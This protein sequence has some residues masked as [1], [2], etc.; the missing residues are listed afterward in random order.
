MVAPSRSGRKLAPA[1]LDW[2][3]EHVAEYG[4]TDL[5]PRPFEI[6]L[7]SKHRKVTIEALKD[8][9]ITSHLW[10]PSRRFLVPKGGLSFRPIVQL[11]PIDSIILSA[12]VHEIGGGIERRRVPAHEKVVFSNRFTPLGD[13]TLYSPDNSWEA[14]WLAS[15]EKAR[16]AAF[17]A[18]TDI[19]DFYNQIAHHT[20]E[21][22]LD[23]SG[24]DP[25]IKRPILRL[26]Q[27]DTD[28][29]SRG[30][31]I[32][33]H[34][35]HLIAEMALIPTDNFLRSSRIDYC[36]F[37]D[38][39]HIF[40]KGEVQAQARLQQ[41]AEYLDRTQK[42]GLSR[43]K[44]MVLPAAEFQKIC[45]DHLM[46]RPVNELE[47]RMLDIVKRYSSSPYVPVQIMLLDRDEQAAFSKEN[48]ETVLAA[49]L[50]QTNIDHVRLRWT[51]RRLAQVGAPGGVEFCLKNFHKMAPAVAEIAAYLKSAEK[52]YAGSWAD[53][54]TEVL[55]AYRSELAQ[56]N[57]YIRLVLLSV[58]SRLR[59]L[60][61][62]S[63]LADIFERAQPSEK[64]KVVL[65][66]AESK[67][68]D[69]LRRFKGEANRVD[70][71]LGRAILFAM[72]VLPEE[73]RDF[74]LKTA[75][76]TARDLLAQLVLKLFTVPDPPLPMLAAPISSAPPISVQKH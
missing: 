20:V 21:N 36:R 18:I 37:V 45:D 9:D 55:A 46:D 52:H 64:R 76:A 29:I 39:V 67:N 65:A 32:G 75:K 28:K 62:F 2:A 63:D 30:I 57:E 26:L 54:G 22:Q 40:C 48:I 50:A 69:W 66:A 13:G 31:P 70:P 42:L 7:L 24:V 72:R 47:K 19:S 60:N 68:A 5:F 4:D 33:P 10:R 49:Y 1:S 12:L 61:H 43:P 3:I 6:D 53:I 17:V 35:T 44:T 16:G 15:K 8:L 41:L 59:D 73:E 56:T 11:D 71:W 27:Q 25:S 58:F 23:E 14:F 74:W 34:A 38:D 51:M